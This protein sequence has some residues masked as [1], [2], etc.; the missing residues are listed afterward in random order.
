MV[1]EEYSQYSLFA[2][3]EELE[4]NRKLQTAMLDIK[5]KFGK[6][7]ILKGMNLQDA[8]TMKERNRQ[9]GGHKVASRPRAKMAVA[10]RAKQFLPF[11]ALKRLPEALAEKERVV[12]PK[13]V[14]SDDMEEL[15]QKMRKSYQAGS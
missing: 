6:N 2:D 15:N 12:V 10:D 3:A 1:E 13:I 8:S 14:L 7:A 9:I 11:A 4:R 5:K